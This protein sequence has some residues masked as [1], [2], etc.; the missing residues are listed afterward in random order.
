[1]VYLIVISLLAVFSVKLAILEPR[2]EKLVNTR[3]E[4]LLNTR[5]DN[6]LGTRD[7][8]L[9]NVFSIVKFP[10]DGCN[11]T[12]NSYGVCYSATECAALGGSS[13]GVCA[14][15]FGV[16][17]SLTGYCGG[18]SSVNNTYFRSSDG[19]SSPCSFTV[20]KAGSDVCQIRLGFDN[21][22]ISQPS[23]TALTDTNPNT[24]SQC[25]AAQFSADSDGPTPPVICGTNTG[26]HM[27]IEAKD[28]CNTITF[29]WT[30]TDTQTWNIHIMQIACSAAWRPGAGCLQYYT[31]V[32]GS[33]FS[34]NYGGGVHLANQHYTNCIRTEQG[35][36][37]ITYT[38]VGTTG[39]QI[40]SIAPSTEVLTGDLCTGDYIVIPSGGLSNGATTTTDRYCGNHL[41]AWNPPSPQTSSGA[42]TT[43]YANKMPFQV[44]VVFDSTELDTATDAE[45]TKGFHIFYQQTAC[46]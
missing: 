19:T 31:G 43:I 8:K 24:R 26:Y 41:E 10:N 33:I 1:M 38:E 30:N 35:Y 36:C 46:T 13:S 42:G 4:K 40:S 12:D 15:G 14:S 34:Y 11:T 2:D 28:T 39:F 9:L 3:D 44:G 23:T 17:C 7:N 6:L 32:Q 29:T 37:S 21:F 45:L 25:Q 5:D 20:C 22:D 18:S 16:C 27:I